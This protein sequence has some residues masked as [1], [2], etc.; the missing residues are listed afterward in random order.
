MSVGFYKRRRGILAHIQAGAVNLL[1][2]GI[3]DYL[4]LISNLVIGNG[5]D[6]PAGVCFTSA[7]AMAAFPEFRYVPSSGRS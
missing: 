3:H 6:I 4:N 7:V 1:E 5:Y 2:S